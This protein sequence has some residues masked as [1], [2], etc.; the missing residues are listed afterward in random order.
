[1]NPYTSKYFKWNS[2]DLQTR[3][4]TKRIQIR[5]GSGILDNSNSDDDQ[6]NPLKLCRH[7]SPATTINEVEHRF[8]ETWN[9]LPVSV[10][11][12]QFDSMSNRL[13]AVL[14]TRGDSFVY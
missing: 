1:M 3:T 10:N 9:D 8:E 5:G 4:Y 6:L 11:Q 7:F 13:T 12:A 14:A 2:G